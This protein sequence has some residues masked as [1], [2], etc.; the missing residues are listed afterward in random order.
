[1]SFSVSGVLSDSKIALEKQATDRF[2][3]VVEDFA[4]GKLSAKSGTSGGEALGSRY[5]GSWYAT[6]YAAALAGGTEYRPKLNFLFRVNFKFTE[7]AKALMKSYGL[8]DKIGGENPS[9]FTFMVKAVDRPKVDF[10]YED[11]VNMYNFRTKALKRIKYREL[12]IDFMDDAGNKVI[13]FFRAMM[14]IHSPIT[15]RQLDQDGILKR[16]GSALPQPGFGTGMKFSLPSLKSNKDAA[17]RAV[18]NSAFGNSIQMISVQQIFTNPSNDLSHATR[19]VSFDFMNPRISSFDLDELSHENSTVN[20]LSMMFDFDW[21]EIVDVGALGTS[22]AEFKDDQRQLIHPPGLTG[23]QSDI[24]PYQ[25]S[26]VTADARGAGGKPSTISN[27]SGALSAIVGR[28][29]STLVSDTIGKAVT[30]IAGNGRFAQSIAGTLS[31]GISGPIAGLVQ[32]A[33]RDRIAS[34]LGV[35]DSYIQSG[36][37]SVQTQVSTALKDF[38]ARRSSAAAVTTSTP[39]TVLPP[40]DV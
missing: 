26:G 17:N 13:N 31:S 12:K 16:D 29:G 34:G 18:V 11:D 2:G 3:A 28:A 7:E 5:D 8:F 19:M 4:K 15:R 6:S 10:E 24:S 14:S 33:A 25:G 1:M 27:I 37:S 20:T 22:T 9:N 38:S 21:M 39:P 23:V 32:G 36:V 35:A 30:S 40:G